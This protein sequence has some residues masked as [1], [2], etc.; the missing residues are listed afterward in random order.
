MK[1]FSAPSSPVMKHLHSLCF[2]ALHRWNREHSAPDNQ[3]KSVRFTL[4]FPTSVLRKHAVVLSSQSQLCLSD[5]AE[6]EAC[7][8]VWAASEVLTFLSSWLRAAGQQTPA[9]LRRS[10]IT[11]DYHLTSS[12]QGDSRLRRLIHPHISRHICDSHYDNAR[13]RPERTAVI[14][15]LSHNKYNDWACGEHWKVII[16]HFCYES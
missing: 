11:V 6:R 9:S 2:S 10:F 16:I 3:M 15:D 7:D 14:Q 4:Q 1:P 13:R 5:P 8:S 12:Q